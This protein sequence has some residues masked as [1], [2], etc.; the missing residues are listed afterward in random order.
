MVARGRRDDRTTGS[1][2]MGTA[3][4]PFTMPPADKRILEN[5]QR[6]AA[7]QAAATTGPE[8]FGHRPG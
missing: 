8:I 3:V 7:L 1:I 4:P 6:A 2:V 5:R